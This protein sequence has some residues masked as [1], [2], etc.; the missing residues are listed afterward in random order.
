MSLELKALK[1]GYGQKAVLSDISFSLEAGEVLCVL[2]P[3]G[4]GKTTLFKTILGLLKPLEGKILVDGQNSANWSRS[5]MAQMIGYIPQAQNTSFPFGV[6]D[7]ILMGRT[8]HL[9]NFASP[10][11]Q[12]RR[13]AKQAIDT[14]GISYL[15]SRIFTELSGGEKQL[16][17]IAR[18][19]AQEPKIL[20]MDEPTS[21][22]DFGNQLKVLTQVRQLASDGLTIIMA[23][24]VPDHAFFYATKVMLLSQG[25]LFGLGRAQDVI[26]EKG[27]RELYG[28]NVKIIQTGIKSDFQEDSEVRMCVPLQSSKTG[29]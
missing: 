1:C 14:L 3:N 29:V 13:I 23:S 8:A 4:T 19:L 7:M 18:A 25:G 10:T 21:A 22:L 9:G 24:H 28:V 6:M 26:T 16:V 5:K 20:V 27:L 11:K 15:E 2:G 12:D 17:L